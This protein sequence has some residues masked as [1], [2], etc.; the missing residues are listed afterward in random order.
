MATK[1]G[2]LD[3]FLDTILRL[4]DGRRL[5]S[6][7]L[8]Y[9]RGLFHCGLPK[10]GT[11]YLQ[12]VFHLNR[13]MLAERSIYYPTLRRG[14]PGR[15]GNLSLA[16]RH[17]QPGKEFRPHVERK[18]GLASDCETLL[19]SAEAL[20]LLGRHPDFLTSLQDA[21]PADCA[22]TFVFYLRRFDHWSESA[23]AETLKV[24]TLE[25]IQ[26]RPK[27]NYIGRISHYLNKFGAENIVVRPYTPRHWPDGSILNDAMTSLGL[28]A[29]LPDMRL[30]DATRPNASM[31]RPAIHVLSHLQNDQQKVRFMRALRADPAIVPEDRARYFASPQERHAFNVEWAEKNRALETTFGIDFN[32]FFDLDTENDDP[33]WTRFEPGTALD[34]LIAEM[35]RPQGILQR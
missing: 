3:A 26:G 5:M 16:L 15:R 13:D 23:L 7:P 9:R 30:P 35:R 12:S 22:F 31:T 29:H 32:D 18:A 20:S 27:P 28:A 10:T 17:Y 19:F 8:T 2:K 4:Q 24:R 14:H 11:T 1:P 33:H 21:F 6:G 25:E 34:D